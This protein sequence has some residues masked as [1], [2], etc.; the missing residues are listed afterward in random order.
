MLGSEPDEFYFRQL[1]KGA[2]QQSNSS[3]LGIISMIYDYYAKL[4]WKI[5]TLTQKPEITEV[6]T[7]VQLTI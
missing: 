1:E 6:T 7:M 4:G 3:Q 5:E 2:E